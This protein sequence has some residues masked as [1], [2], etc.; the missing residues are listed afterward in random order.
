MRKIFLAFLLLTACGRGLTDGERALMTPLLGD[1]WNADSARMVEA[2]F[3]GVTTRT[4]AARPQITCRERIAPAPSGPTVQSRTA[5]AVAWTHVLT[6]TDWTLPDYAEGYPDSFNLVAAMFFAHEMTHIWQ[7][8]NRD[9]T[10]YTPFRGLAEHKPGVDPY[11]FDSTEQIA[12]L[13]LGYEQ[14]A[15]MV[16]EFVCCRTIAPEAARTQRLYQTLRAVMPVEHPTQTPRAT[17]VTGIWEG[18]DLAGIC[19]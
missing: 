16:E 11:L 18:A 14:Q 7:W 13:D 15:S 6:S 1:S 5:G 10:G 9:T 17:S 12:F 4:F 2:P 8:Q 19:D 3:I